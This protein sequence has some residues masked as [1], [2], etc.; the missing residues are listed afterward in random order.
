MNPVRITGGCQCGAV[1]YAL[2]TEIEGAHLCHCRMCQKQFGSYFAPWGSV[3]REKFELTRGTLAIFQSSLHAER[4]FCRNCGTPLTFG[5]IDGDG[6]IS[7][8]LGS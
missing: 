8:A 1:R 5:Y 4:G 6:T 3:P 2:H 7:V